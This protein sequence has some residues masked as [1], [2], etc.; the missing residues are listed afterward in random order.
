[1]SRTGDSSHAHP[2]NGQHPI[3]PGR[4]SAVAARLR[5]NLQHFNDAGI[6][7]N[8]SFSTEKEEYRSRP[9]MPEMAVSSIQP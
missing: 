3:V 2:A 9:I 5:A 8:S 4:T 6:K 7:S 1:M